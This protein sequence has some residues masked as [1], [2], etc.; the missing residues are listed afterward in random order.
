MSVNHVPPTNL[1]RAQA[2]WGDDLPQWI[3]LL[4]RACDAG[5]QRAVA[6]RLG[7]SGGYISRIVNRSYAGSYEEAETIVRATYGR[8]EV[9][10]PLFG[11]IPLSSCVRNRRRKGPNRSQMHHLFAATCPDCIH[12]T[13]GGQA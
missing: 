2:A 4:A 11:A 6:D 12:N 5:S 8:D 10:C 1:A 7:K 13:D 3:I 9:E